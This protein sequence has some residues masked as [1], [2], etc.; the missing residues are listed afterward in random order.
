M[1]KI[2]LLAASALLIASSTL[3]GSENVT[4]IPDIGTILEL[5]IEDE[6]QTPDSIEFSM[7]NEL[8]GTTIAKV[9]VKKGVKKIKKTI[10]KKIKDPNSLLLSNKLFPG[11]GLGTVRIVT[12][13]V[14][15][16]TKSGY[17][18]MGMV[19]DMLRE[20][21]ADVAGIQEIDSCTTRTGNVFQLAQLAGLTGGW[22]YCFTPAL[23][24]Y[25]GGSYGIGI[26]SK[27]KLP[28]LDRWSL[29]L[30]KGKGSEE[31]ALSVVEFKKFVLATTHLDHKNENAQFEQACKVT[32]AL[33][34]RYAGSRKV[35]ILCGDFNATPNSKTIKEMKKN[36]T[37]VSSQSKTYPSDKAQKCID[38]IMVLDNA[39][40]YDL[41]R[42]FVAREFRDGK[43]SEASDHLPVWIDIRPRR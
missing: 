22:N 33:M 39:S 40:S 26:I 24:P 20:M 16:F 36:W 29:E 21:K 28:I 17:N 12:Y 1:K 10:K 7:T 11:K 18:S 25:Q 3:H 4:S 2:S 42:S 5:S 41:K 27:S 34:A 43:V 37:L 31:R 8:L 9:A 30:E 38:Y 6:P 23:D 35:I 19:S 15:T 13:N 32:N 14:G